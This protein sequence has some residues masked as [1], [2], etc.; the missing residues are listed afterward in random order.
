MKGNETVYYAPVPPKPATLLILERGKPVHVE[1]LNGDT[2][3]GREDPDIYSDVK[4]KSR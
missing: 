1:K 2:T 4:L 3:I